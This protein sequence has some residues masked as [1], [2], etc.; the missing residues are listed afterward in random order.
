[1]LRHILRIIAFIVGAMLFANSTL[2]GYSIEVR[3][4]NVFF[5][6]IND[7]D[8]EDM[9]AAVGDIW[10]HF[11][12]SD[13]ANRWQAEG[14]IFAEGGFDG[15]PPV[16]TIVT[17]TLIEKI[18]NVPIFSGE[19]DFFHNYA[20]SGLLSHVAN[21]DGQLDNTMDHEVRGA[22]LD[23]FADINGQSLGSFGT[24]LYAGPGPHPFDDTLGPVVL[25]TTTQHHM[26]LR[27]YLDTLGDSIELFNSA[28]LHSGIP[29]PATWLLSCAAV[30]C[31]LSVR[32]RVL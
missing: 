28:E 23:Y 1:M 31:V 4:D 5:D 24:G 17:D 6:L 32:C 26:K 21:I 7:N 9:N 2:A 22:S 15:E 14:E 30:L 29:E 19:I 10:Y 8:P 11:V 16:S 20:A 12:L 25:P 13:P 27:F 18:A 3:I